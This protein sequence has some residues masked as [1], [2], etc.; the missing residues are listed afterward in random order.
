MIALLLHSHFRSPCTTI[1]T[2]VLATWLNS[3]IFLTYWN[4]W[5][6]KQIAPAVVGE[7]QTAL[8][9]LKKISG[10]H[11]GCVSS[12]DGKNQQ[13]RPTWH[14]EFV[15]KPLWGKNWNNEERQWDIWNDTLVVTLVARGLKDWRIGHGKA[16]SLFN[17]RLSS[18]TIMD[19]Q[20]M[21]W[22][23]DNVAVGYCFVKQNRTRI[24]EKRKRIDAYYL[25]SL[26]N[27]KQAED[28]MQERLDKDFASSAACTPW[29]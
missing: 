15:R 13:L 9:R 7:E 1:V 25:L 24:D 6:W 4:L 23:H 16:L 19:I 17:T 8:K 10:G 21:I 22:Q 29:K 27:Q 18:E 2:C 5:T 26:V 14:K 20:L 12:S 3:Q 11:V 28:K